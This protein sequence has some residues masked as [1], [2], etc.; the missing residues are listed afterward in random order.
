[1]TT[2]HGVG[3]GAATVIGRAARLLITDGRATLDETLLGTLAKWRVREGTELG[4]ILIAED[5]AT[6][7]LLPLP[8]GAFLAGVVAQ[9]DA[10]AFLHPPKDVVVVAGVT[11]ALISV[12]EG[13]IVL[14]DGTNGIVRVDPHASEVA[15]VQTRHKP[16]VLLGSAHASAFT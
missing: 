16:R 5:A 3:F 13:Q 15:R 6:A 1:V 7:L 12:G 11:D 8:D 2:L 4:L 14:I 9:R 10:S